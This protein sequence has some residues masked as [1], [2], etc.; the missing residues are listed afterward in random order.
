MGAATLGPSR[1]VWREG[2][3]GKGSAEGLRNCL[4][5]PLCLLNTLRDRAA[6]GTDTQT[7]LLAVWFLEAPVSLLT[8]DE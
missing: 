6:T 3:G 5:A 7:W 1:L 8:K 2:I 4:L